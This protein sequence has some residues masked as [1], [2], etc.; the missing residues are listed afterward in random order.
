MQKNGKEGEKNVPKKIC[1][2]AKRTA[3]N[4]KTV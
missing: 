4:Q 2:E 3:K 1:T